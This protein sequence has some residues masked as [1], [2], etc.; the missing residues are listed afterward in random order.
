M[1][2]ATARFLSATV[3]IVYSILLVSY[4]NPRGSSLSAELADRRQGQIRKGVQSGGFTQRSDGELCRLGY[5]SGNASFVAV[6][7]PAK[8]GH[9]Y[10]SPQ[11]RHLDRPRLRVVLV[12]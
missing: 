3:G 12:R 7:Q 4:K 6:M 10:Q 9:C 1:S 11:L 2:L 5:L 8:W